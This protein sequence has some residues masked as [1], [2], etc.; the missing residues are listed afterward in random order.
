[1]TKL[2]VGGTLALRFLFHFWLRIFGS[3]R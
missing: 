3:V 2:F 1:L